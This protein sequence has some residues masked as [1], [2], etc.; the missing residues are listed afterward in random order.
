M[1]SR[2]DIKQAVARIMTLG[3]SLS[4]SA[5]GEDDKVSGRGDV[6]TPRPVRRLWPFGIRSVPPRDSEAV[7]AAIG[8]GR[9]LKVMLCAEHP[10]HGPRDLKEGETALYGAFEALIK[11]DDKGHIRIVPKSAGSRVYVGGGADGDQDALV[12]VGHLNEKL[13]VITDAISGHVHQ[14]G[15]LLAGMSAVTGAT[16]GAVS[17]SVTV[18]GSPTA[19]GKKP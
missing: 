3:F 14:A 5:T 18:Q 9:Y 7:I 15:T 8:G 12:T 4:S 2:E 17:V 19:Y 10:D 11:L 6:D 16:A 13:K 1:I